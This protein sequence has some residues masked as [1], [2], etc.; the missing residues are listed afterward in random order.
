MVYLD[1]SLFVRISKMIVD[2]II[3]CCLIAI[4]QSTK[5]DQTLTH[6]V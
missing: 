2:F 6:Q 3:F 4:S 1:R 5:L